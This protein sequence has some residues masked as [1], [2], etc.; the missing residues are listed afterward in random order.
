MQPVIGLTYSQL[1]VPRFFI[2]F[3][4]APTAASYPSVAVPSPLPQLLIPC[5]SALHPTHSALYPYRNSLY[6]YRN[7]LYPLPQFLTP[8]RSALHSI[9]AP[10]T[11]YRSALSLYFAISSRYF[12]PKGLIAIPFLTRYP[13]DITSSLSSRTAQKSVPFSSSQIMPQQSV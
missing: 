9:T 2:F 13:I 8:C 7:S 6:P 4:P 3:C 12:C 1:P 11:L 10:Y 5:R